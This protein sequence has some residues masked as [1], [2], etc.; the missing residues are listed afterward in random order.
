[1]ESG[2]RHPADDGPTVSIEGTALVDPCRCQ[3]PSQSAHSGTF[4]NVEL[5]DTFQ[6]VS[7]WRFS[8]L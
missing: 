2:L 7:H 5:K 4:K 1:M 8:R 3:L 6:D